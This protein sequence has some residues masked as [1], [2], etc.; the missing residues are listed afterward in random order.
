MDPAAGDDDFLVG[1]RRS[2]SG[3]ALLRGRLALG[4]QYRD[5]ARRINL[6]AKAAAFEQSVQ[7]AQRR[8]L[9][10]RARTSR[11]LNVFEAVD[12]L[13]ARLPGE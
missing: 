4:R 7:R 3:R 1:V 5:R 11:V 12:H 13:L 9:P 6:R 10:T 2:R 8:E